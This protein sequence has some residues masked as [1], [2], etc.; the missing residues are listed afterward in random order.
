MMHGLIS[1]TAHGSDIKLN[2]TKHSLAS[3][4]NFSLSPLPGGK[5]SLVWSTRLNSLTRHDSCKF[6]PMRLVYFSV[7][8]CNKVEQFIDNYT[9]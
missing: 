8:V 4:Q 3:H 1:A 6:H 9:S 2:V 5:M 7:H